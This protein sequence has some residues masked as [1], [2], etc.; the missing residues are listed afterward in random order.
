MTT[1]KLRDYQGQKAARGLKI[2]QELKL[3]YLMM[4]V[5][6][7]KT[8]TALTIAQRYGAKRVLFLTKKKAMSSVK[9]DYVTGGY[10]FDF[11][12]INDESMHKVEGDFDLIIHDEHHRFA[13]F[14]KPSKGAMQF[15]E[16]FQHLPHIYLSG[17]ITPENYSQL[18]HQFWV[19]AATPFGEYKSFYKWAHKFV[20]IKKK[21][22]GGAHEVNDYTD[23]RI[24]EIQ[25]LIEPYLVRCTQAEAGFKSVIT[26]HFHDVRMK[27]AT[28]RTIA[29][30]LKDQVAPGRNHCISAD[31]GA[32]L[33]QKVHQLSG[34]TIIFDAE[35]DDIEGK[36]RVSLVL[37]DNKARYINKT[38]VS[39]GQK[40]GI[41]YVFKKELDA[42]KQVMGDSITT[43]LDEF[44]ATDKS[45]ALQVVSGREGVKLSQADC[46]VFYNISHSATSYWQARD[47][48]TTADSLKSDV[49]WLLSDCGIERDIY[50]A[51]SAKKSYTTHMFKRQHMK[52]T[53][54]R[55]LAA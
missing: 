52:G 45:I 17:T 49:H 36:N 14:P 39:Q 48:M 43:D 47:R 44:N 51:V 53:K 38:W 20:N 28:A 1:F 40:V 42:L 13:G 41:F 30:L 55:R 33:M 6:T 24:A 54:P 12:C 4:E 26:E 5:R 7:G 25:P 15:K 50:A 9:A 18:Y 11:V 34:G 32:A 35:P 27:A 19:S 46:L 3:V 29:K 10:T 22:V 37:D 23:A 21:Y 16:N 8:H 2:L 31:T